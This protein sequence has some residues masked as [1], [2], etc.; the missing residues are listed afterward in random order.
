MIEK[1]ILA[2]NC[3][4]STEEELTE[5]EREAARETA[6]LFKLKPSDAD[7]ILNDMLEWLE[8]SKVISDIYALKR[9]EAIERGI[10]KSMDKRR[11]TRL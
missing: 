11:I 4:P 9:I 7:T 2:A 5:F 10:L 1:D 6:L 8:I 3:C